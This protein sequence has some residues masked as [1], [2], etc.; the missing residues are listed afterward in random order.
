MSHSLDAEQRT[1]SVPGFSLDD[2]CKSFRHG[3]VS[4]LKTLSTFGARS[5]ETSTTQRRPPRLRRELRLSAKLHQSEKL[6][7]AGVWFQENTKWRSSS[8]IAKDNQAYLSGAAL[9]EAE[10]RVHRLYPGATYLLD[11]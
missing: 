1:K 5:R 8:H 6:V 4:T 7:L 11:N 9:V 10:G 2:Q 3:R